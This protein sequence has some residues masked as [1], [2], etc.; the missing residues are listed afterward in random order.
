MAGTRNSGR[1]AIAPKV[2]VL[3]GTY[4]PSRH[5]GHDTPE[6]PPG[7]PDPPGALS[8]VAR[9]EWDR[10][11]TRLEKS[12]TLSIVDDAALYQYANL[13]AE[14]EQIKADQVAQRQLLATLRAEMK[15]TRA[16]RAR[17]KL[18]DRM[19]ALQIVIAKATGALRQGHMA[20]RQYLVEFGMTPS[21]R[22][23]VKLPPAAPA[24]DP[25]RAR[26][27]GTSA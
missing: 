16:G 23:R 9:A 19:V 22:T 26:Y 18:V 20:I 15:R 27:F 7:T 2:H 25:N 1:R 8:A 4:Q 21:A 24:V 12:R 11:V 3:R 13:Y 5:A 17:A 14:T 10:M 6:P